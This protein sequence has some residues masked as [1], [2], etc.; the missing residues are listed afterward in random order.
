MKRFVCFLLAMIMIMGM[1][2]ATAV[3]ASAAV[4][5][6]TTS[7]K[8][9]DLLARFEGF[10]ANQYPE[11]GKSKDGKYYIGY[12]TQIKD[13]AYPNGIT[14]SVARQLLKD[15]MKTVDET[16]NKF[17]STNNHQLTQYEHDALAIFSYSFDGTGNWLLNG[18]G[19]L[20]AAVLHDSTGNEF[21]NA[22]AQ[23][24][25][26]DPSKDNQ[27]FAG[28]MN[29]R[30]AEANLY[31][32]NSYNYYAPENYTYVVLD[33][34]GDERASKGD[35]VIA[36]NSDTYPLLTNVPATA[37]GKDFAG[38]Y[39]FD[40]LDW[41]MLRGEP[42]VYLDASTAGQLLVAKFIDSGSENPTAYSI[43]TASL[44]YRQVFH[45]HL[46]KSD[47]LYGL[48]MEFGNDWLKTGLKG[49]LKNNTLFHVTRETMVDG[50]KWIFGFGTDEND[51]DISG[52][53]YYGY[54]PTEDSDNN[55]LYGTIL[56][57]AKVN[58]A[59]LSVYEGAT[60]SSE[61]VGTLKKDNVVNIYEVKV[62]PTET[63]NKSWGRVSYNG[64]NGWINMVY[65]TVTEAE[66]GDD[67]GTVGTTGTIV[68]SDYVNVR[69]SAGIAADNWI[70]SLPR[71]T[72]VLVVDTMTV[73]GAQWGKVQWEQL[74]GGYSEGWVYMYY[75]Q[76]DG[77]INDFD[78][79]TS[80]S[81]AEPVLYTGVVTS[82][83]NLNIREY[84]SA[85]TNRLGSLPNGTKINI[86]E[87][88]TYNGVEWG[89]IYHNGISGW[90]CL[91]YV[92]LTKVESSN[93]NN[94]TEE[95]ITTLQGTVNI[96]TLNVLKNYNS[97]A[98][99]VGTLEKG[100]TVT[101]L[102]KNTEITTTGSRIWGRIVTEEVAG[103]INLAYV[104][105]KTVTTVTPSTGTSG[106]TT[107]DPIPAVVT[108]CI[109][110]NVRSGAGTAN[111]SI[112]KLNNGTA[113][114]VVEQ[115]TKDNAPWAR[116]KWNN[117]AN[118][119][120]VCMYY[121]TLNA[122]T[123]SA[124]T[125]SN[126]IIN[127]T[128]SNTISATGTVNNV[129]L[130][131]RAGAGLN[132]A[133]VG[134]LNQGTKVTIFE[135][136]VSD[137]LIWGRINYN[138][139]SAW[140]CMTYIT[141]ES[142]SS[143]GKGVM[144]TVARCFSKAN[145][146]SA[147]GTGNAIVATVNVGSRVEVFEVKTHANQQWGRI[148]Q[149]WICMEY[150]LLDSELPEG[151]ILDA[152][153]APT[154]TTA[155]PSTSTDETVN[156]DGEVAFRIEAGILANTDVRN[157]ANEKSTR[158]GTVLAGLGVDILALKNNGAELWGRVDQYGTAGWIRLSDSNVTYA[159][160]GY[161]NMDDAPVYVEANTSST[162]KGSLPINKEMTFRKVT[163]DGENV[164]GWVEENIYGWIPMSKISDKPIDILKV[165]QSGETVGTD[166]GTVL[167]G[168]TFTD[169]DAY[170]VIG[171]SKVLFKM[172]S[173]VSVYVTH[174]R[175]E[176]GKVWGRVA[177]QDYGQYGEAWF[178]LTKVNY[179]LEAT[180]SGALQVRSSMDRSTTVNDNPNNIVGTAEGSI[181]I[182]QLAFD[183]YGNLWARVTAN[184]N[185]QL[186]GMFVLIRT[187]AQGVDGYEV[188]DFGRLFID[189]SD[190]IPAN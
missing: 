117:G 137:G 130:N 144:G 184:A 30:L 188:S 176:H 17:A 34:N 7:D 86:Y 45:D 73:N 50:V 97:N 173:G 181:R 162:V 59:T 67:V 32:N 65:T 138:N 20:R 128:S 172:K 185:A 125:N 171:G 108:D 160:S 37:A 167:S 24:N 75:I 2:P 43:N 96:A 77:A 120:W 47:W 49:K 21:I 83:I 98:A 157:D 3:T 136:A 9:L 64:I 78:N 149:G 80:D 143:T 124:N 31:L 189:T 55:D 183:G 57:T 61:V 29:R 154:E 122:G 10:E 174:V 66:E 170:D 112:T 148:P 25:G 22:I 18:S 186:N 58:V 36:Y 146:R 93:N 44:Y 42:V 169:V 139:T 180:F 51:E 142:A 62:E 39:L 101:I 35:T 134:T 100:D 53:V 123:G 153:T 63:G 54:L 129:Y 76:L 131:V 8:A 110:V 19:P 79:G 132:F 156:K 145:V 150:V 179:S 164:Y 102:E 94:Q 106:T 114:T 6:R 187:A 60:I 48:K 118:E 56:A 74:I 140:V 52:W 119:G 105:L 87:T 111:A 127:G 27:V 182:C 4:V 113:V 141:V 14:E 163:T 126:G 103:W 33:E 12:G 11:S 23:T 155:A 85:S 190:I 168:T 121:L 175:F 71:G 107:S 82:N 151:T 13:G 158:V 161:V 95:G 177:H 89:R 99:V 28:L 41:G 84:P 69:S 68:G 40:G 147:P 1:V 178:D 38:W 16:L 135:Q 115:V 133:Q 159:F 92:N 91:Q 26:G 5:E 46:S 109:S 72:K 165:F 70:T 15:Y 116:I 104:D 81:D 152:T 166:A 90:V 88:T